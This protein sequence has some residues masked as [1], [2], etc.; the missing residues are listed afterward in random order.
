MK[1]LLRVL[2]P[3]LLVVGCGEQTKLQQPEPIKVGDTVHLKG[4]RSSSV[5]FPRAYWTV[6]K[7]ENDGVTIIH[8]RNQKSDWGSPVP[9]LKVT[10]IKVP[11]ETIQEGW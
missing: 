8:V 4:D 10:R 6:E 11:I 1:C 2:L 3:L 9:E 5:Q 7:L